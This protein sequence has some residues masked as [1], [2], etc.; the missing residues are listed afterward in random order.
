LLG[1]KQNAINDFMQLD[2]LR[3]NG[4]YEEYIDNIDI[5]MTVTAE[6]NIGDKVKISEN[7]F[8][9]LWAIYIATYEA[10]PYYTGTSVYGTLF[11][12]QTATSTAVLGETSSAGDA[13][14]WM[15]TFITSEITNSVINTVIAEE[16][17]GE[18][19][20]ENDI[21]LTESSETKCVIKITDDGFKIKR[22]NP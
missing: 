22:E 12:D 5:G 2:S 19:D 13:P 4:E 18:Y 1:D 16:N 3:L 17:G 14:Y 9:L 7:S 11:I 6:A 20:E 21:E 8:I 10:C 15:L